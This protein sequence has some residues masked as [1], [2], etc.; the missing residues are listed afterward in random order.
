MEIKVEKQNVNDLF[1]K[2]WFLVPSYQRPYVWGKDN[3]TNL[4]DDLWFAFENNRT[5]EY[6]LGSLVLQKT[7]Q[8]AFKEYSILDGQQRLTSFL[9]MMAV[10]RDAITD[11]QLKSVFHERIYQEK[12][13]G[14]KLPERNRMV[15]EIREDVS[16]FV[17]HFIIQNDGTKNSVEN[18][19]LNKNPSIAHMA[20]AIDVMQ[21]FF[22]DE[23]KKSKLYDFGLYLS[24]CPIFIC[25]ST[26]N[27]DDA[28]RLFSIL[29]ARGV[30]LS[31]ADILKSMNIG[32]IS[33]TDKE[34]YA[35]KWEQIESD[36]SS[37]FDRFLSIIRTILVKEKARTGLLNEFE[38]IYKK[39]PA[40]LVKGRATV[41]FLDRLNNHYQRIIE[42]SD[43][44]LDNSYKNL[45]AIM[46][47]AI[48]SD[49]WIAPLLAFYDKFG[50]QD[51]FKFLEKLE[52]KFTAD[53]ILGN[54][55]TQRIKNMCDILKDIEKFNNSNDV[56][57]QDSLNK[58]DDINEL[59][60]RLSGAIYGKA[61]AKFIL[62]KYE[63]LMMAQNV[64]ISNYKSVSIEHVLP[65]NPKE[66]SEWASIFNDDKRNLW[67]NRLAN[68]V[69]IDSKK[70][71]S[72]S[73]LDF[74][75]KK[76]RYL[77][78][79]MGIFP[80]SQIFL[81]YQEWNVDVL[82]QRQNEMLEKLI[83]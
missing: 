43:T 5:E 44:G 69:L 24:D 37:D 33:D 9:I 67:T 55:P 25:V 45:I 70:N 52:F 54:T 72:L 82:E 78:G 64:S 28:F 14:K 26:D 27:R 10:L 31:S 15:Y 59:R 76:S 1:D 34:R 2:F 49:D 35:K 40:I 6:F 7:E 38:E 63:Y 47:T 12:N 29:N 23:S 46:M 19:K 60:N 80:S 83:P 53:W 42:L 22:S 21:K 71:S 74:Q 81:K 66:E 41:D 11:A 57:Y 77:I 8:Q 58:I 62:L 20:A 3:V 48:P 73:N 16:Q 65:Q 56:L 18:E 75:D 36:H 4:L 30:P 32:E 39:T 17:E 13:P 51:L 50:Q 61:F 68:L 79:K